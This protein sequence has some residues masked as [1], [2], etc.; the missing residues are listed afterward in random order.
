MNNDLYDLVVRVSMY[1]FLGVEESCAPWREGDSG[2]RGYLEGTVFSFI[3]E[4][5]IYF[6]TQFLDHS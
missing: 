3:V 2:G 6:F 4:S 5:G 1:V